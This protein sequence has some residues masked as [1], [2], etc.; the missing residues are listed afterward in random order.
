MVD[1]NYKSILLE[2]A[3]AEGKDIPRYEVISE[4]GPDHDKEFT[5]IVYIGDELLGTGKGKSKK[6]AEQMAAYEAIQK[7]S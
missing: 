4:E 7:I 1:T 6:Q 2:K 3:Q 5:I